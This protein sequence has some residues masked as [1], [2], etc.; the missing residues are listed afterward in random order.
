ME[1]CWSLWEV[2]GKLEK[3]VGLVEVE[4]RM[5]WTSRIWRAVDEIPRIR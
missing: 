4:V 2:W 1:E 3:F 5:L